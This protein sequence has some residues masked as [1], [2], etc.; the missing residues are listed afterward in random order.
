M[1]ARRCGHRPLHFLSI[2]FAFNILT[3]RHPSSVFLLRKNPLS[4]RG[5]AFG[6][7]NKKT[8]LRIA[9]ASITSRY[10]LGS[11]L[12]RS[13]DC[14]GLQ[15]N[16]RNDNGAQRPQNALTGVPGRAYLSTHRLPDHVQPLSRTPSHLSGLSDRFRKLTLLFAVFAYW[17]YYT[18]FYLYLSRKI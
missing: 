17:G 6:A 15:S 11:Q 8:P 12:Q 14:H 4:P 5:K 9:R 16:P 3:A 2:H 13:G 7:E 18:P 1:P 10:H